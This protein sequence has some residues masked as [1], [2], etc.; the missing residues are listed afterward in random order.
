MQMIVSVSES[1]IGSVHA[2]QPATVSVSALPNLEFAANVTSISVLPTSSS[3]VVSYS[4]TLLLTQGS[5]ELRAGMSATAT[6]VTAQAA[7]A[8]TVQSAAISSRG[9]GSTVTVDKNGTM[10]VTPV[11]T[12]IVGSSATQIVAGLSAGEEVAIPI[13][14][15]V[16]TAG[17]TGSAG[18]LGGGLGGL[19]GLG[20][21]GGGGGRFRGGG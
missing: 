3:G 12:G 8:V 19:A 7:G 6:I 15:S 17:S 20:G 16:A 4:V 21:G 10:V 18:T 5:S 9:T 2:G 14:T 1:D 11:I 13:A